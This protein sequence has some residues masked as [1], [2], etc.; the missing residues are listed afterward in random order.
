MDVWVQSRNQSPEQSVEV[1]NVVEAKESK[2]KL[3]SL[4][5]VIGIILSKFLPQ[6]KQSISKRSCGAY[7][8]QY[9]RRDKCCGRTNSS[10]FTT[11]MHLLLT[12]WVSGNIWSRKTPS[13]FIWSY[14]VGRFPFT[15]AQMDHRRGAFWRREGHQNGRNDGTERQSRRILPAVHRS[16]TEK[17]RK[18]D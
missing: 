1:S 8:A 11:T 5:C 7:F 17:V 15:Q 2:T 4:S 14:S 10:C 3:K 16:V 12:P 13:L 9:T 6:A 18:V